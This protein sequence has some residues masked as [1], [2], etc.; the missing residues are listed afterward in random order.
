[1]PTPAKAPRADSLHSRQKLL[2]ALGRL[3]EHQGLDVTLPE[4]AREAG[5]ST[6]TAYRHFTDIDELR[7]EFYNRIFDRVIRA[8]EELA[9]EYTGLELF[10]RL[11]QTWVELE[12]PWARA[13]TYIRSAEGI[14]ERVR[15]GEALSSAYHRIVTGV[16]DQLI[17][18]GVIPA[19]DTDYAALLWLTIFD[20][21][22]FVDLHT[23]KGLGPY[24]I[25]HRLGRSLL[26]ALKQGG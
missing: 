5:V 1:V 24:E 10:H 26:A 6:A 8:M 9:G 12:L 22:V 14:L 20:E 19:Q 4:L 3:L 15:R 25:S 2:D 17:A 11:C 7:T 16:L 18:D 23:A 13:A 21:R